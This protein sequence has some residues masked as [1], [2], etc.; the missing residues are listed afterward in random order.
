MLWTGGGRH[1]DSDLSALS[2]LGIACVPGPAFHINE[3]LA[4][5]GKDPHCLSQ[6]SKSQLQFWAVEGR[7]RGLEK[8][9]LLREWKLIREGLGLSSGVGH[10]WE[11]NPHCHCTCNLHTKVSKLQRHT[12]EG[13][14]LTSPRVAGGSLW[15]HQLPW[16]AWLDGSQSNAV[17]SSLFLFFLFMEGRQ[18]DQSHPKSIWNGVGRG[19]KPTC[20]LESPLY[21]EPP[22][23]RFL[24]D[25]HILA[26]ESFQSEVRMKGPADGGKD[27]RMGLLVR[28]LMLLVVKLVP[29][30]QVLT[31]RFSWMRNCLCSWGMS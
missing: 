7:E 14:F 26:L 19:M 8:T 24:V 30:L 2:P 9:Q 12:K 1:W 11:N 16:M 22:E 17:A 29:G 20:V 10:C 27:Q 21:I 13:R 15:G 4:E 5:K 31:D 23:W 18:S 3:R 28:V 25:M 6:M